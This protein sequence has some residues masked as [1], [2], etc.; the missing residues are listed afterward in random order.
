V[1]T[2]S[3]AEAAAAKLR[4]EAL[5]KFLDTWE[6]ELRQ[7]WLDCFQP[8]MCVQLTNPIDATVVLIASHGDRILTS[9]AGDLKRLAA[10]GRKRVAV[11]PC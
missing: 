9:D 4:A 3:P 5:A 11:L 1:Y 10:A 2:S 7:T 6:K 8:S